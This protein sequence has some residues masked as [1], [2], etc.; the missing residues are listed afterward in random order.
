LF[1]IN[2]EKFNDK[3]AKD[4]QDTM[5]YSITYADLQDRAIDLGGVASI[6][7]G[8]YMTFYKKAYAL[9]LAYKLD[10]ANAKTLVDE[11]LN[12]ETG[13]F[14]EIEEYDSRINK[15]DHPT[16][17]KKNNQYNW[18]AS[19]GSFK[20]AEKGFYMVLAVYS[21]NDVAANKAAGYKIVISSEKE[22]VI[23]GE[24]QWLKNNL[25][26][27][28]LF[29]VAGVMLILIIILLFVKPSDETLEEV[30]VKALKAKKA[31][32]KKKK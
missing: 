7:D 30:D 20:T 19:S 10:S 9:A 22:D 14:T 31:K 13:I 5:L 17:W 4:I 6:T 18:N 29:G 3:S 8:D 21:D 25:V 15:E 16:E 24:T 1:K 27:V 32:E 26:S 12:D 23:E 28:I 2:T 11:L